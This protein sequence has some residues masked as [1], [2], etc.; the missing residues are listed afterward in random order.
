MPGRLPQRPGRGP[1]RRL[2]TPR[3]L[4]RPW[5]PDDAAAWRDAVEASLDDLRPWLP[6]A[7]GELHGPPR[8]GPRRDVPLGMFAAD[9]G[10]VLGG[11]ALHHAIGLRGRT[12]SYW[13]A[14]GRRGRGF[15]TEAAGALTRVAFEVDGVERVEIHVDAENTAS[16]A[17]AV[18]LGFARVRRRRELMH[19]GE[20]QLVARSVHVYRLERD[21]YP[22]A[23]AAAVAVAAWDERG[24]QVL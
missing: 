17:V 2:T 15:A 22:A 6:W 9:D 19:V 4:L 16:A 7:R 13:L 3:L 11:A 1:A 23:P 5:E 24:E 8:P 10:A 14:S 18:R 21:A 20:P 12:V